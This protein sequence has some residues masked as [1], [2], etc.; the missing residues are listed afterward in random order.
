MGIFFSA[1]VY[2]EPVII[3]EEDIIYDGNVIELDN[4]KF[5]GG[6]KKKISKI[7]LNKVQDIAER[8]NIKVK[9]ENIYD[10]KK[11]IT[12]IKK[13]VEKI[14]NATTPKKLKKMKK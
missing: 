14:K 11:I 8:L 2:R 5:S 1:P 9:E 4:N 12:L 10:K 13:K 6:G 7:S 3:V